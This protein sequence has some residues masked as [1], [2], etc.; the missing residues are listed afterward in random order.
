M[1]LMQARVLIGWSQG[2][3]AE[4][5]GLSLSTIQRMEGHKHSSS[6]ENCRLVVEALKDGGLIGL[7]LDSIAWSA[8]SADRNSATAAS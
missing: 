5:T 4:R 8:A 3:L 1:T 7:T 6:V 2:E